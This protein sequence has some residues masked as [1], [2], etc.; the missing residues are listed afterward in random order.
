VETYCAEAEEAFVLHN[1]QQ[2]MPPDKRK[3]IPFPEMPQPLHWLN[4]VETWG[5]PNPGT[6]LDQPAEFMAD[7]EAARMGQHRYEKKQR[8]ETK[9][10]VTGFDP[11]DFGPLFP[12][13]PSPEPLRSR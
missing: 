1:I 6:W 3:V 8:V 5:L 12:D 2:Q 10:P 13:A 4:Q 7:L 11:N 9:S